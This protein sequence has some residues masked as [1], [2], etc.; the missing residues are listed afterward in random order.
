[1]VPGA[2]PEMQQD[3]LVPDDPLW[4][5]CMSFKTLSIQPQVHFCHIPTHYTVVTLFPGSVPC[6]HSIALSPTF[7]LGNLYCGWKARS[8]VHSSHDTLPT[9]IGTNSLSGMLY[10]LIKWLVKKWPSFII[11]NSFFNLPDPTFYGWFGGRETMLSLC[12]YCQ[13]MV[14]MNYLQNRDRRYVKK[15]SQSCYK[16]YHQCESFWKIECCVKLSWHH[17]LL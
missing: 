1:M 2:E 15:L 10:N 11:T 4:S 14:S 6:C 8:L 12:W 13:Q 17:R 7:L 16:W 5:A 9:S 3:A